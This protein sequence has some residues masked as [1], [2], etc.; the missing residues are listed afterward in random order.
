M[1]GNRRRRDAWLATSA[2]DREPTAAARSCPSRDRP[3]YFDE[4]LDRKRNR[5]LPFLGRRG[6]LSPPTFL[7][8]LGAS[9]WIDFVSFDLGVLS[10]QRHAVVPRF[11]HGRVFVGNLPEDFAADRSDGLGE[12]DL[13]LFEPQPIDHHSDLIAVIPS[14]RSKNC[15]SRTTLR[16]PGRS[17]C[18]TRSTA[19]EALIAAS[20]RAGC[21]PWR[22]R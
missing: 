5:P 3:D 18:A 1:P 10:D 6:E 14:W 7:S 19:S 4:P 2:R 9:C 11:D 21:R 16:R 17:S 12:T 13:R 8:M 22:G 20:F 15:S